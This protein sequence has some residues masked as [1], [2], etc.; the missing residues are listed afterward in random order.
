MEY[1]CDVCKSH[2]TYV[3]LLTK[4]VFIKDKKIKISKERR[5]CKN[6]NCL[7]YDPVLDNEYT[8]EGIRL[9]NEKYGL[10]KEDII[11]IRKKLNLS[12]EA[13]AK[14]IGCAKKTLVSYETGNSIPNDIYMITIKTI[15]DNPEVIK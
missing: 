3:K 2:D 15:I 4:T 9:Y 8:K 5:F 13:F 11:A 1:Q 12:V 6:C 14:I 10:P 7:V